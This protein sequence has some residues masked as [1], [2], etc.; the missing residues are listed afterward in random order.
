MVPA[1]PDQ[2]SRGGGARPLFDAAI[3]RP[4]IGEGMVEEM[5]PIT[6][7]PHYLA[8]ARA[9]AEDPRDAAT[10]L[11]FADWLEENYE[12][13]RGAVARAMPGFITTLGRLPEAMLPALRT[14]AKGLN[15]TVWF[16]EWALAIA[17]FPNNLVEEMVTA[18]VAGEAMRG[19]EPCTPSPPA[20]AAGTDCPMMPRPRLGRAASMR[21]GASCRPATR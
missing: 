1:E 8:F 19:T 9:I 13:E 14:I 3:G 17:A 12:P 16:G 7:H 11:I 4:A 15:W 21:A 20:S 2:A 10:W 5:S 6:E 18:I